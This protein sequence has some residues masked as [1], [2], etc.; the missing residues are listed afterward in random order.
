MGHL[1]IACVYHG[2]YRYSSCMDGSVQFLQGRSGG[3]RGDM[4]R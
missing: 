1:Y 4:Q 2:E 3:M